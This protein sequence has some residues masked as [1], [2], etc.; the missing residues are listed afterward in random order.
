MKIRNEE[1]DENK[2][3]FAEV[4]RLQTEFQ[5]RLA[6][7]TLRYLRRLQGTAAPASPGTVV[8]PDKKFEL[9]AT[10]H[11]AT[12]AEMELE[13]ENL[14]RV[15]STAT[16]SLSPLVST[17]GVTWFAECES[18]P[19]T[20]LIPPSSSGSLKLLLSIPETLPIG[21]YRGCLILY[22]FQHGALPVTIDVVSKKEEG[23][24]KVKQQAPKNKKSS[25]GKKKQ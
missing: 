11:P 2:K 5:S 25:P 22:G 10:A 17:T 13:I 12:V 14:Q 20:L 7:E 24:R 4:F 19:L 3:P 21:T 23:K 1:Q 9:T 18:K 8:V 15:H 6:D 16:P